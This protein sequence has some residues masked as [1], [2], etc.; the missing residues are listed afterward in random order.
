MFPDHGVTTKHPPVNP[1]MRTEDKAKTA[2]TRVAQ[3]V[4]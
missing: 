1:A 3:K 4:V 2:T